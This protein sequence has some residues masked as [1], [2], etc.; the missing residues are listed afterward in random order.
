MSGRSSVPALTETLGRT[1]GKEAPLLAAALGTGI[2][3]LADF[4][5]RTTTYL[6]ALLV[7]LQTYPDL[8]VPDRLV[9]RLTP[10][11]LWG[12][13]A[14]TSVAAY[15]I[16]ALDSR[17]TSP[18]KGPESPTDLTALMQEFRTFPP[19]MPPSLQ[20]AIAT[21]FHR[22][23]YP[24][25]LA[26]E[27]TRHDWL[28]DPTAVA[29]LYAA[30]R[31]HPDTGYQAG[32]LKA[33]ATRR[34][35]QKSAETAPKTHEWQRRPLDLVRTALL[36]GREWSLENIRVEMIP[37]EALG[38]LVPLW[39]AATPRMQ[40]NLLRVPGLPPD[41]VARA[42]TNW[43]TDVDGPHAQGLPVRVSPDML[44][45]ASPRAAAVLLYLHLMAWLKSFHKADLASLTTPFRPLPSPHEIQGALFRIALERTESGMVLDRLWTIARALET[46]HDLAHGPTPAVPDLVEVRWVAEYLRLAPHDWLPQEIGRALLEAF[47]GYPPPT[48]AALAPLL[49]QRDYGEVLA[50]DLD[51]W[52]LPPA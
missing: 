14:N 9:R 28:T 3:A 19:P 4:Q 46:I 40:A 27:M 21:C 2:V 11:Q 17:T 12:A 6:E 51:P 31:T 23:T 10:A 38:P 47:D 22:G 29:T 36:H 42:L 8:A 15:L 32:G 5:I 41:L 33:A 20:Q 13:S 52:I 39:L 48:Q 35:R 44:A 18:P 16:R 49:A 30:L 24:I 7:A 25:H 34:K 50:K 45:L 26:V 37:F 1:L 43:A